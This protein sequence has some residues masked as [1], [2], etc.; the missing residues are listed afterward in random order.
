MSKT[1]LFPDVATVFLV[2]VYKG[3]TFYQSDVVSVTFTIN[4]DTSIA[5]FSSTTGTTKNLCSINHSKRILT[6]NMI[7][8][9]GLQRL[10][11][12]EYER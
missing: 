9:V 2:S 10:S 8:G 3:K 12:F 5:R 7:S 4:G 11:L 6:I 1:H